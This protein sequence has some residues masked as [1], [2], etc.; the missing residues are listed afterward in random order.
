MK[1][2]KMIVVCTVLVGVVGCS[3]VSRT[4]RTYSPKSLT[5][6]ELREEWKNI[7]DFDREA[8]RQG[9]RDLGF[10]QIDSRRNDIKQAARAKKCKL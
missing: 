8:T 7:N 4:I 2:I 6:A 5:C 9:T 10:G 1:A 3:T